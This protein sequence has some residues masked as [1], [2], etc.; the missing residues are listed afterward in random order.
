[1]T[2]SRTPLAALAIQLEQQARAG[3]ALADEEARKAAQK[4][5]NMQYEQLAREAQ[6]RHLLRAVYSPAQLQEQ[7][8]W[9]WLNHFSVFRHKNNLRVLVAD[10]DDTLRAHALGRFRDLLAASMHHPAMLRYLDNEHNAAAHGNENYARELLELHTLGVGGGYTQGDVQELA[11]VLTG[12]G[13]NLNDPATT[14]P[15]RVRRELAD[16]YVRD[17]L[18]E[19]NPNRHDYGDKVLLGTTI[20]GRGLSEVDQ[21]VDLLSRHPATARFVSR[22]IATYFV[23]DAPS[24][25]LVDAMA[26]AFRRSDG[27]IATVLRVLFASPQFAASLQ[28]DF[29][30]P[31]HYVVSAVRLAYDQRPILNEQPMINWLNRMGEGLYNHSTPDGYALTSAGW[32]GPGQITTRFEIARAIGSGSAGLF[33]VEGETTDQPAFPQLANALYYDSMK[34]RLAPATLQALDQAGSPQE[35]NTLLLAAPEFMYR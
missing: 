5:L 21:V 24:A 29:K 3:R 33:R 6:A 10:Y 19:F 16:Q 4:D 31:M 1:M 23:G 12:L 18:F 14:P 15:P 26:A 9:F 28:H 20:R 11:R 25:A 7:M 22:Q 8:T 13:V 32:T 2:I 34:K 35:W 17:G 27:D 30:D